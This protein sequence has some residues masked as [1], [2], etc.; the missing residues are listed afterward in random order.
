VAN[1]VVISPDIKTGRAIYAEIQEAVAIDS[2]HLVDHYPAEREIIEILAKQNA[3]AVFLH[4]GN[5]DLAVHCASI[6]ERNAPAVLL[7]AVGFKDDPDTFLR[8][9]RSGFR[10]LIHFP[11]RSAQAREAIANVNRRLSERK[12][13]D[14]P[15]AA[16][17]CFLP[18][19]P[20]V[21]ASTVAV[22][23][24]LASA[25]A[26]R[27]LLCDLDVNVSMS[28]FLLR[29]DAQHSIRTAIEAGH[30]LDEDLWERIVGSRG[31]LDVLGS[32][33]VG[34]EDFNPESL[35][36]VIRFASRLYDTIVIDCSG[37]FEPFCGDLLRMATQVFL[38]CT[39]EVAALHL[40]RMKAQTLKTVNAGERVS[41]LM[42]RASSADA[43]SIQEVEKL[44]EFRVRFSFSNDYRRVNE[45]SMANGAVSDRS[46]LG[47]QFVQ[48][49][50]SLTP[51]AGASRKPAARRRFLE[52]FSLTPSSFSLQRTQER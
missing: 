22:N 26:G 38:V 44:L 4:C 3:Q 25:K 11:V 45:A 41:I 12:S 39:T 40:G 34:G 27:T 36:Q 31:E 7:I 10:E 9:L 43:L 14:I 51:T 19:K 46:E 47:K 32:G 5:M 23:T 16:V 49:A 17:Y 35:A 37:N 2:A 1:A 6:I 50:E 20:G 24:A 30:R 42:N 13:E 18:A 33:G 28:A 52:F 29:V 8:L 15:A 21:G 48:F